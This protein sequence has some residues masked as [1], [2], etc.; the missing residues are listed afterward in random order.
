M[1]AF[2]DLGVW[3][4]II[5][6]CIL[7]KIRFGWV[8]SHKVWGSYAWSKLSWLFLQ[9]PNLATFE[10]WWILSNPWSNDEISLKMRMFTKNL[11]VWLY[12]GHSWLL[13]STV[14]FWTFEQLT[15]QTS[16]SRL[17]IWHGWPWEHIRTMVR[18]WGNLDSRILMQHKNLVWGRLP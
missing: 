3:R 7:F 15:E 9:N 10:S 14:D 5:G 2:L 11:K 18:I 1:S 12:I 4:W 16:S 8:I 13:P 17:E 6:N